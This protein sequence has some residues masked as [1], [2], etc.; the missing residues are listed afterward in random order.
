VAAEAFSPHT[1]WMDAREAVC[2][3]LDSSLVYQFVRRDQRRL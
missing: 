1:S 2:G 3:Y